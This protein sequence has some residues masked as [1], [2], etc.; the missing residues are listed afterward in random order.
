M[1]LHPLRLPVLVVT[2]M[3]VRS[4]DADSLAKLLGDNTTVVLDYGRVS[5]WSSIASYG[6]RITVSLHSWVGFQNIKAWFNLVGLPKEDKF[7]VPGVG[8]KVPALG[9]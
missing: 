2:R 4:F 6:P 3:M 7:L 8:L 5:R 9:R 1:I